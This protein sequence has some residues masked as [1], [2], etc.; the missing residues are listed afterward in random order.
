MKKL[1]LI[2][3]LIVSVK[4]FSQAPT[5]SPQVF[6]AAGD[7]RQVGTTGIWITDN[8]GEPFTETLVNGAVMLT[9][10]FLQPEIIS[11]TDLIPTIIHVWSGVTP[12][13][14]GLNDVFTIDGISEFPNNRVTIFNRWGEQLFDVKL[15]DNKARSWPASDMLDKLVSSTYFYIVDLGNGSKPMKGWVEV[16]KN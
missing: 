15:Y 11:Q 3:L 12:N 10:G 7:H 13:G 14:D 1:I 4:L 9:Q 2:T 5:I 6:N 8:I 16:I